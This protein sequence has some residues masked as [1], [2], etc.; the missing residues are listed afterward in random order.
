MN[1]YVQP[2]R[3][4]IRIASVQSPIIPTVADWIRETPGTISLG[5]GVVHYP[6]P[7]Q[8]Y[9]HLSRFVTDTDNHKYRPVQGIPQLID[10]LSRKLSGENAID[11]CDNCSLFVTAGGN[12]AFAAALLAI[13][14]EGEEII[15]PVPFYF[16]HE[17]A[18]VM[19]GC[20]PVEVPTDATFQIAPTE[21]E[22]AIGPKTRAVVTVSPNNPSGAVYPREALEEVSQIC[23]RHGIYHIHDEAYEYFT[24]GE[25]RH[26]SPASLPG[27]DEYTI[28]LFSLS[29]SFG[30]AS[31]RIG[32]MVVPST[33]EQAVRKVLDTVIICPPV[34][35]QY[36]ALGALEAGGEYCR[37]F[38]RELE[39]TRSFALAELA[40]ISDV[41]DLPPAEGAFYLLLR[42]KTQ[43]DS[44]MLAERLVREHRV[45]VI[46]GGTFGLKDGCYL[47]VSYGA[48]RAET[49][50]EGVSRLVNGLKE[51]INE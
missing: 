10:A 5:Q 21:I 4:S 36:A 34:I 49:A 38:V 29:K 1:A 15:L 37:G 12:M 43:M 47:R 33:L 35:S 17:M 3:H 9:E 25:A 16:N 32:Y 19:S 22:K 51:L 42:V 18:V 24:Y 26:F 39:E 27:A 7:A 30:F 48:L 6:P 13:A 45:A 31:W 23:R 46:P 44:E 28:S 8:A 50:R 40:E 14:D 20:L 11:L 41:C 2:W